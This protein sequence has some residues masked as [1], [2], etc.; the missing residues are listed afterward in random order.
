MFTNHGITPKS[1]ILFDRYCPYARRF[2][3]ILVPL[4][5]LFEPKL[6]TPASKLICQCPSYPLKVSIYI[7]HPNKSK[8]LTYVK[9]S[10]KG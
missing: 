10:R 1:T 4:S 8:Q 7:K 3:A 5:T 6:R 9:T 2:A